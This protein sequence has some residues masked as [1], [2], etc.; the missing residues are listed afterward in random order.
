[1]WHVERCAKY[2]SI[3]HLDVSKHENTHVVFLPSTFLYPVLVVYMATQ[4]SCRHSVWL[5][6]LDTGRGL[7]I[8]KGVV[9]VLEKAAL[10]SYQS[11]KMHRAV[12]TNPLPISH[13]DKYITP[14][15]LMAW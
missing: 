12:T 4:R 5:L 11:L 9:E 6:Y 1:L 13:H 3:N 15:Y 14:W 8:V 7:A 2:L 10:S